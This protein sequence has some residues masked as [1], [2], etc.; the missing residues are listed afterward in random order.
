MGKQECL[1]SQSQKIQRSC[2]A[3][4]SAARFDIHSPSP[5]NY[6]NTVIA[7]VA[8][9]SQARF[10]ARIFLFLVI[11]FNGWLAKISSR[12]TVF[13]TLNTLAAHFVKPAAALCLGLLLMLKPPLSPQVELN[14][15]MRAPRRAYFGIPTPIGIKNPARYLLMRPCLSG[16]QSRK[17][18]S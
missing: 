17:A 8:E 18:E 2:K 10:M 13:P 11:S 3:A 4:V 16:N 14:R 1:K 9:K 6:S 5:L 7:H 12:T 15:S